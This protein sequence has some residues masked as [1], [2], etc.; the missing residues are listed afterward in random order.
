[1]NGDIRYGKREE[2]H[3][4]DGARHC[5]Q[6][7]RQKVDNFGVKAAQLSKEHPVRKQQKRGGVQ[8]VGD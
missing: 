7:F 4:G 3:L 1:M 5:S 6:F 2:V 8:S